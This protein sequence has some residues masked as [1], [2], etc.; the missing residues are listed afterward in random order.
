MGVS[1][2][3]GSA[4][5]ARIRGGINIVESGMPSLGGDRQWQEQANCLGVDP[6]LF[7]PERGA[8]T[9]EAK[10]V[11][12]GCVVKQNC[13]EFALENGEKFGIWGGMSERERRKLRRQ[14]SQKGIDTGT[15]ATA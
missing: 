5:R 12:Q 7:F 2:S 6:D 14:R 1:R 8:S 3:A 4:T 15:A 11:C 13:L 9:R 10:G